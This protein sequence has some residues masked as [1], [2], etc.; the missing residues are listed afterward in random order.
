MNQDSD[1]EIQTNC[2]LRWVLVSGAACILL[3]VVLGAFAAHGLKGSLSP[4][5]LEIFKTAASYQM[6]QGFGLMIIGILTGFHS[7]R[8]TLLYYAAIVLLAGIILFSGSLF[9]L[10]LTSIK[11][12]GIITP[13]GGLCLLL[14]WSIV[15]AAL[16]KK[17]PTAQAQI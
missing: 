13:I 6:N 1:R 8:Q 12:L 17:K 3:S 10:A 11:W 2:P 15:I 14:A 7:F 4:Y 5:S 16:L 9:L